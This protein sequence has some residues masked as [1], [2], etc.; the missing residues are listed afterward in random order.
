MR[1]S[2]SAADPL[3]IPVAS[4]ILANG[5]TVVSARVGGSDVV[6]LCV[7]YG[8][9]SRRE[10]RDRSGFAHL[11]EHLMFEG[12]PRA[13]KGVFD[14]ACEGSG[15]SNNGQTRLDSTLYT[16]LF[17]R[18]A[19]ERF[20][21]LEADRLS[22]LTFSEETLTNQRD[23]VK[24]EI[25]VNVQN[26]P[27][28]L[29]EYSELPRR[30]F[31]LWENAHDGYGDF[32]DLDAATLDDVRSFFDAY[33]RP[34]NAI[35]VVAG[36]L[37]PAEV[38]AR[39]EDAFGS[40]PSAPLPPA[41]DLFEPVRPSAD[42][43]RQE[44]PLARTPMLA[45]GWRMPRRDHPDAWPLLVLGELLHDGRAG[46]LFRTMVEGREIATEISGGFNAFQGGTWYHGTT[47]FLTRI[48]FKRD[49]PVDR[50]LD[51]LH[52]EIALLSRERI[53]EGELAR[54]KTKIVASYYRQ[55]ESRVELASELGQAMLFTGTPAGVLEFALH[56]EAVRRDDLL[57]A[58]R[59]LSRDSFAAVVKTPPASE[60]P[61]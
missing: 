29:F 11:F 5:L 14:R 37:E 16:E 48:G 53:D 47:L 10:P 27:Y 32:A 38:F 31:D 13:G 59:W 39:A 6:G 1:A 33:Y 22:G 2:S 12:T 21:W 42:L 50:V 46:R 15:G 43:L 51:A 8:I 55:C 18:A 40:I 34:N 9:G 17:P 26:D 45:V 52:E 49:V 28:G 58:T 4:R 56:V 36:D 24:E 20:L 44:A 60:D 57:R 3:E 7:T 19:L 61:S 30:L 23:V 54:V 25:R 41:T 35:L